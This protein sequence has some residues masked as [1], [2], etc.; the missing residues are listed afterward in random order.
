M[1]RTSTR[2]FSLGSL[3]RAVAVVLLAGIAG[4]CGPQPGS[5]TPPAAV[6]QQSTASN[7][8]IDPAALAEP[9]DF[10]SA[11][12]PGYVKEIVGASTATPHG[13]WSEQKLVIVRL[14]A[15]LPQRVAVELS[16]GG[17]G[18]NVGA[19]ARL[20]VGHI[21]APFRLTGTT[22]APATTRVEFND[23]RGADFVALEV[24]QPAS[25]SE[26]GEGQDNRRI[27]VALFQMRIV[28]LP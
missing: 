27:G 13:R 6:P 3:C 4:A 10:A 23:L 26:R 2:S 28:P 22:A 18:P 1:T 16:S 5:V 17:Y 14:N 24:P 7:E 25:P 11:T 19:E 20:I 9:L 21:A 12:L 8:P 15:A